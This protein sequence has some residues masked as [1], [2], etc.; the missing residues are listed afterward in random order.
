MRARTAGTSAQTSM[1]SRRRPA[2]QSMAFLA[3]HRI[4]DRPS[5]PF[6]RLRSGSRSLSSSRRLRLGSQSGGGG[7]MNEDG[8][9]GARSSLT[10]PRRSRPVLA[11]FRTVRR[12]F[13]G[14][15]LPFGLGPIEPTR[16]EQDDA[17]H[18]A[19]DDEEDHILEGI[20]DFHGPVLLVR[21][22]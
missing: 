21:V 2:A 5:F 18:H 8:L 10:T 6:L 16:E 4:P 22:R 12:R 17:S 14:R 15:S 7:A 11:T 20:R 13:G 3:W 9:Q 19:E 1:R